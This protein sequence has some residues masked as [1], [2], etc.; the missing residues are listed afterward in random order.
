MHVS[1]KKNMNAFHISTE[2]KDK[3]SNTYLN[4][5]NVRGNV[6]LINLMR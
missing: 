3:K 6:L 4:F 1:V 5:R 2:V